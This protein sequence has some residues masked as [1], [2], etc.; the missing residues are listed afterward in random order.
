MASILLE[1]FFITP[2]VIT[3]RNKVNRILAAICTVLVSMAS[4]VSMLSA[5]ATEQGTESAG[6]ASGFMLTMDVLQK[7]C[8]VIVVAVA[9]LVLA[10]YVVKLV[11]KKMH[12]PPEEKTEEKIDPDKE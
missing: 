12:V 2:G 11:L 4:K 5:Y 1:H 7:V 3:L 10:F 9:V 8:L 6:D